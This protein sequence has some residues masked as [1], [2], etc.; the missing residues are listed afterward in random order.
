MKGE[1]MCLVRLKTALEGI[2]MLCECA[3]E[4]RKAQD[5]FEGASVISHSVC[6]Q[7]KSQNEPICQELPAIK[8]GI[9]LVNVFECYC[10]GAQ[11]E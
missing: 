11:R 5:S 8:V 9:R 3:S 2:Q 7:T 10:T 1:E 4:T 6:T